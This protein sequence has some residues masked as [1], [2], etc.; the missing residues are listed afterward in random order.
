MASDALPVV[1]ELTILDFSYDMEQNVGYVS[2]LNLEDSVRVE[3]IWVAPCYV[4][5]RVEETGQ[6]A[7]VETLDI[8]HPV[9]DTLNQHGI[10][11][12]V[13]QFMRKLQGILS[14]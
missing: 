9:P 11:V 7:G 10:P 8:H 6:V 12:N 1:P 13:I 4:V 14:G 2:L 3:T 5:D